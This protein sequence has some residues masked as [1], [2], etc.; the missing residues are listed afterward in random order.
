[1][2]WF[3]IF[4]GCDI[5]HTDGYKFLGR[6]VE[7]AGRTEPAGFDARSGSVRFLLRA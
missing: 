6:T 5:G 1:M 7:P 3:G 4:E 2:R